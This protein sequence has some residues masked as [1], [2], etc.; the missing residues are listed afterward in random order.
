MNN[1]SLSPHFGIAASDNKYTL[2]QSY[3]Q[4]NLRKHLLTNRV[5][6]LWKSLPDGVV[7]ANIIN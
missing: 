4:Y 2:Y 1:I 5:V 6:L 7:D 3:V